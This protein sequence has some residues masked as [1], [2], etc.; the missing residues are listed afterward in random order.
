MVLI[1]SHVFFISFFSILLHYKMDFTFQLVTSHLRVN[2]DGIILNFFLK[3]Q[4]FPLN[5]L[6]SH[7]FL[8]KLGESTLGWNKS[9]N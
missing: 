5:F 1:I 7:F 8:H 9:A 4:Q 2:D 6:I 3:L